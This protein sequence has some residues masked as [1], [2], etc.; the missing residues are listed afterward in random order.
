MTKGKTTL[1]M[2]ELGKM[3]R[4]GD[5]ITC[6]ILSLESNKH[7]RKI[8]LTMKP[9]LINSGIEKKD[10]YV[11]LI[12][13]AAVL[14]VEDHGYVMDLG[15]EDARG[16]LHRDHAHLPVEVDGV[17]PR[18]LQ[19]GQTVTCAVISFTNNGRAVNLSLDRDQISNATTTE[20]QPIGVEAVVPGMLVN[21]RIGH[22]TSHGLGVSFCEV[23]EGTIDWFHLQDPILDMEQDL[24][25]RY[26]IGQKVI[27]RR[28][29]IYPRIRSPSWFTDTCSIFFY[30]YLDQGSSSLR[31]FGTE[32]FCIDLQETYDFLET[33]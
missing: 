12:L 7:S 25:S 17:N 4:I 23:F 27:F 2:P 9:N 11:N 20:S 28:L 6:M 22:V 1:A 24:M 26:K 15:I 32:E 19:E 18:L 16:F 14:S 10:L 13:S 21:A 5:L 30:D 8:E 33:L 29:F 3:F 31:G